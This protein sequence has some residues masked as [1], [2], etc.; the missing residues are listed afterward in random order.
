MARAVHEPQIVHSPVGQN[1]LGVEHGARAGRGERRVGSHFWS[2]CNFRPMLG[3]GKINAAALDARLAPLYE[4]SSTQG[5]RYL[6]RAV[7]ETLTE[8][9]AGGR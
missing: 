8:Q 5:G 7:A 6:G 3:T 2:G 1:S 9:G 4:Y